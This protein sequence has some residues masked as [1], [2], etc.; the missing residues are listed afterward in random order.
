MFCSMVTQVLE[1]QPQ[2]VRLP[3]PPFF[4]FVWCIDSAE[5]IADA[6]RRPLYRLTGGD[7]GHSAEELES[8]LDK[9]FSWSRRWNA[10][11]LIDEADAFMIKRDDVSQIQQTAMVSGKSVGSTS[12]HTRNE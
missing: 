7:L 10:V 6:L 5:C 9:S 11:M 8:A 12:F 4:T 2:P 1:K 3:T